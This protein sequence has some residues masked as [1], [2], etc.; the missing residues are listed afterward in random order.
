[1]DYKATL[2]LPETAFPMK[3]NLPQ[4]EPRIQE[5]WRTMDLHGRIRAARAG[6]PRYLLHDGPPYANGDVHVGT[7]MNKVLKDIVVKHR[8]MAGFDAPFVP[9]WDCHGQPI[10]H[11]VVK[12]LGSKAAT[13]PKSEIRI[14]CR[15][16][17]EKW[18]D[19]QRAQFQRLGVFGDWEHPYLTLKPSYEAAVATVFGELFSKGY[20]TRR[21]KSI[22]WC[23]EC[24]TALAEAELEYHDHTSPSITVRFP[25]APDSARALGLPERTS[26]LTWTTTPWTLPANL[27][28]ALNRGFR[29]AAVEAPAPD[30]GKET[31]LLYEG[32]V[33]PVLARAGVTGARVVKT[34]AAGD[35]ER[36]RYRHPFLDRTSGI[37]YGEYVSPTD[38][39]G[40]VHTAPG[41]GEEDYEAGVAA[42][43][44]ILSPVDPAGRFTEEAGVFPG[45]KVWEA[46]PKIVELLKERGALFHAG[47]TTHSYP[48]CWRCKKP[49]IFR[50][51]EQWFV[52][53]DHDGLR[54][55]V[56]EE[57]R[58]TRWV[59]GWGETRITS[60]V[61]DRPDW[62]ISR[63]RTWGVPIPALYCAKCQGPVL[64]RALIDAAAA[65][66]A[67]EGADAWFTKDAAAIA[68]RDLRC[69][70]CGGASFEKE[71]DIFDVWFESGSS[72][73][74]VLTD[75]YGLSFPA[76][77]YLEGTDQHRG[78]FQ[79]SM[80]PAKA[81]L[82]RFPFRAVVTHGFM[83]DESGEK[84]SKSKGG[85][86]LKGEDVC[87]ES[88]AD[89]L[90]LWIS[91][92]D[93][94]EDVPVSREIIARLG[95]P[96]RRFRNTFRYLL[97]S[98]SDFDPAK[99]MVPR[100]ERR[101]VDRWAAAAWDRVLAQSI[102]A[103]EA[104]DFHRMYGAVSNFCTVELS[105]FYLDMLKDR[106]YTWKADGAGR[107]SAQST[108]H[109]LLRGLTTL[110]APVLVHTA[111]EV[112]EH[113]PGAKEE[114]VH[115]ARFPKPGPADA[116]LL[117]RW[118]QVLRVRADVYRVLEALRA[119]KTIGRSSEAA[120]RLHGADPAAAALLRSLPVEAWEELLIVSEVR[121]PDAAEAG[122]E[123]G[124]DAPGVRIGAAASTHPKCARCWRLQPTVGRN[125]A[126]PELC[127]RCVAALA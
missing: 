50:A 93:F 31:L 121:L 125:A 77:L 116:A 32:L 118:E 4:L 76:D 72:H 57:I 97:G 46:N 48:H 78:W 100:A 106:L 110:L 28:V 73:R 127:E 65:L 17:A 53:I 102:E 66:F 109:E 26:L 8:T 37:L 19:L 95:E 55:K 92:I 111:E 103:Y 82:G 105:S 5:R 16:F 52:S 30:G 20:V 10:E 101:E 75:E 7:A 85:G 113:L 2:R 107:R 45:L 47:T 63:Q 12:D 122:L 99:H 29:Y 104:F 86:L 108:L 88:G 40:C 61:Q 79:L 70:K 35:L 115:L 15:Q 36:V 90:R 84:I 68:P 51:T 54:A 64:T 119:A 98:L 44:P 60:M 18:I 124:Q 9:G 123:P 38:G 22:H 43:L 74:A 33:E 67:K 69:P 114:S 23:I 59:P 117:D 62:C 13:L 34:F 41:H 126:H 96:Y 112:W 39:T 81:T 71:Q 3:A 14:L 24:R 49:V 11:R 27:A 21:R 87:K 1:L 91:S 80:I 58:A 56:L 89:L 6:A 42:G 94:K 83:V 120:V 25:L